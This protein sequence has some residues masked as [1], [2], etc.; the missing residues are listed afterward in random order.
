MAA[1]LTAFASCIA[2]SGCYQPDESYDGS[3][4][5]RL[6]TVVRESDG[7]KLYDGCVVGRVGAPIPA[8][9][10]EPGDLL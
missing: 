1:L 9:A 4:E 6:T 8:F 7:M 2:S 10:A 5:L 3:A